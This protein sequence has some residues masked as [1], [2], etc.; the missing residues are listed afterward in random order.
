MSTL[1]DGLQSYKSKEAE[2]EK[3]IMIAEKDS[4]DTKSKAAKE[5]KNIELDA[6][7]KAKL[8]VADAEKELE[9]IKQDIAMLE[10]QYAAYKSNFLYLLKQQFGM[11][12]EEDFAPEATVNPDALK[13]LGVSAG[14]GSSSGGSAEFGSFSGD[15][16]MRDESTL[17]GY[18]A[19]GG[20]SLGG[21]E[22][23]NSTSAVYTSNLSAGENFVDPFNPDAK[24][25]EG[26][27]NPYDGMTAE[28]KGSSFSVNKDG[29]SMGSTK[30][31]GSKSSAKS[32]DSRSES[33][34][35]DKKASEA[36]SDAKKADTAK[37]AD[38]AG[39][40]DEAKTEEKPKKPVVDNIFTF[41][42]SAKKET[43][44]NKEEPA[45]SNTDKSDIPTVDF[46]SEAAKP[47]SNSDSDSDSDNEIKVDEAEVE[48]EIVNEKN[49]IGD[50][51]D[52]GDGDGF[53]FV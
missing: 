44:Q 6:K 28:S 2:L 38:T 49:L 13:L 25:P 42:T 23:K 47:D 33:K 35:S 24:R 14:S 9:K 53:E 15:P 37:A 20:G 32:S 22:M 11:L 27:Y 48:V 52:G 43:E 18:N 26:R 41:D 50:G 16:Q 40:Q 46:T 45:A 31:T 10:T 1:T 3:T 36:A 4:E 51:D 5:A 19:G 17:G 12:G 30:R 39:K 8:I 29:M 34:A 7:N 21:D